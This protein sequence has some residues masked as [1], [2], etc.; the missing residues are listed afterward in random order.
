MIDETMTPNLTAISESIVYVVDDDP[1]VRE[2]LA[3]LFEAAGQHCESFASGTEFLQAVDPLCPACVVLDLKMPGM[4]GLEV[5]KQLADK[6]IDL[7]VIMLTGHG[8]VPAAVASI[9]QGAIDFVQKPYDANTLLK[10]THCA[11]KKNADKQKRGVQHEGFSEKL[12]KLSP[13]ERQVLDL[14]V[15]GKSTKQIAS[16]FGTAFNTVGNQRTTI[17]R[18][19]DVHSVAD[20]VRLITLN[21][22]QT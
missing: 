19:L 15:Q 10:Q 1:N 11:I 18:K 21:Q 13:R 3:C 22:H 17:M 12:E 16:E 2:S 8:D 5:Q 6:N 4:D 7:P 20:L 9:K 14:I